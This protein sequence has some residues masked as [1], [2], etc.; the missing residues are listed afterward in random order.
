MINDVVAMNTANGRCLYRVVKMGSDG[1]IV[2]AP[3]HEANVNARDIARNNY[4]KDL[5]AGKDASGLDPS[6]HFA[7][8]F[9]M[10]SSLQKV[11]GR[12]VSVSPIGEVQVVNR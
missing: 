1:K 5:K 4:N 9:K 11:G 7:Y 12:L 2:F 6:L 8:T 3:L 10:A